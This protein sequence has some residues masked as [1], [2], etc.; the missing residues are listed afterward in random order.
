MTLGLAYGESLVSETRQPAGLAIEGRDLTAEETGLLVQYFDGIDY[1]VDTMNIIAG[2]IAEAK[3][4]KAAD[5]W[6]QWCLNAALQDY[7]N[8]MGEINNE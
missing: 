6:V 1:M 5:I 3:D 4:E 2:N 8:I 7:D